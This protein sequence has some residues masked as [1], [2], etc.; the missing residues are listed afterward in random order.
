MRLL[1]FLVAL[2]AS[3]AWAQDSFYSD[4]SIDL[5]GELLSWRFIDLDLDGADELVI[6]V[7]APSGGRELRVHR[8]ERERVVLEPDAVVP[9]LGDVLAWGAADVRDEPGAELLLLTRGGVF[10][11]SLT[12]E[13]Y[14]DNA[15]PLVREPLVYDLPDPRALPFWAYTFGGKD[16]RDLVLVPGREHYSVWGPSGDEGVYEE[17]ARWAVERDGADSEPSEDRRR[18]GGRPEATTPFLREDGAGDAEV[19]SDAHRYKAPA[20]VDLEGD[21]WMDLVVS[22]PGELRIY[23]GGPE[24]PSP[25]RVLT[26]MLPKGLV[27]TKDLTVDLRLVDVDDDGDLDLFGVAS[28]DV[29]GFENAI[30][31]V[32]VYRYRDGRL[33]GDKPDQL[34]RFEGA[35]LRA[36]IADVDG[37]GRR[38]LA[39]RKFELPSVVETVT[40]LEFEFRYLVYL[41]G[42]KGFERRPIFEHLEVYDED[43][44]AELAANRDLT[45]DCDGDG[46]ADLVELDLGG[47]LQVR[48]LKRDSGFFSGETWSLEDTPWKRFE[49]GGQILSLEVRDLNGDSVGDIVSGGEDR[50]TVLLSSKRRRR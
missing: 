19:L 33:I 34:L 23:P 35:S 14:R 10:S 3:P 40:G 1:P 46:I 22:S 13:G 18:R 31:R 5:D 9:M 12:L 30:H 4:A 39:L 48:R 29:D 21:G 11:Y 37:D 25:E 45:M 38:D 47:A 41:G 15:R 44:V 17:R 49:R 6:G 26:E 7:R 36:E 32:F 24:G 27:A 28:D 50:L 42:R 20:L 8:M 16:G 2:V 43:T